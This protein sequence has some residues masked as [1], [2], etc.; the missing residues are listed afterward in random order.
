LSN[1]VDRLTA[2]GAQW[3]EAVMTTCILAKRFCSL[4]SL[5]TNTSEMNTSE[6][7]LF[8]EI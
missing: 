7:D 1:K 2:Y 3:L 4:R 8:L 6:D 5:A